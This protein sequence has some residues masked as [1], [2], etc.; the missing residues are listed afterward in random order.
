MTTVIPQTHVAALNKR[1][2]TARTVGSGYV[3]HDGQDAANTAAD[4]KFS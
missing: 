3:E 2:N 4:K 1:A